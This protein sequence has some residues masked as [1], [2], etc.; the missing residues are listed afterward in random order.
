MKVRSDSTEGTKWLSWWS[1]RTLPTVQSD[2]FVYGTKCPEGTKCPGYEEWQRYEV[3]YI[4]QIVRNL[5]YGPTI[6]IYLKQRFRFVTVMI[7]V[8]K[9]LKKYHSLCLKLI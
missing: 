3:S 6:T 4:Q 9:K 1:L 5:L 2:Q 8:G 7:V